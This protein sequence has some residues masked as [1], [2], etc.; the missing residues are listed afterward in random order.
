MCVLKLAI[1]LVFVYV[2]NMRRQHKGCLPSRISSDRDSIG[3]SRIQ[4]A[5]AALRL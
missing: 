4:I 3:M 1:A 2:E 5:C